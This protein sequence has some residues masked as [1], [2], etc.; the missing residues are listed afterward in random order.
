MDAKKNIG[1]LLVTICY[2]VTF[3]PNPESI[4]LKAQIYS[5]PLKLAAVVASGIV[6]LVGSLF[7]QSV[8]TGD[9]TS[10]LVFCEKSR[11]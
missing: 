2:A 10:S 11:Y 4:K 7:L 3:Y 9:S 5:L 1:M 6:G 8:L